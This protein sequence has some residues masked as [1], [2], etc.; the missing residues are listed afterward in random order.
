MDLKVTKYEKKQGNKYYNLKKID[1]QK[2]QTGNNKDVK[3]AV[4]IVPV[5]SRI[6]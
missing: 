5:S 4:L 3:I 2:Q 1:P 6:A